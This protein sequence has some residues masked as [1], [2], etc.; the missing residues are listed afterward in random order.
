MVDKY[1][2]STLL[3]ASLQQILLIKLN[4]NVSRV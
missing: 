1:C 4:L 2:H 3:M